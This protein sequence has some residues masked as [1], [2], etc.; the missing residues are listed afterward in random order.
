M[1]LLAVVHVFDGVPEDVWVTDKPELAEE[2]RAELDQ[3][4]GITG[5]ED[6]EPLTDSSHEVMVLNCYRLNIG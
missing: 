3:E 5:D 6:G 2:W 1:N 4:H